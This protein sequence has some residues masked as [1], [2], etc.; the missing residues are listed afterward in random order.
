MKAIDLRILPDMVSYRY[1][2]EIM[3]DKQATVA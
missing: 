2:V 3:A 1:N